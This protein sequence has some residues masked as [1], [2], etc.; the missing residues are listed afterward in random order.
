MP[1]TVIDTIQPKNGGAF[2]IV[3]D[4]DVAGG[5]QVQPTTVARDAIP[6]NNRKNGMLVYVVANT[7]YYQLAGDLVTWNTANLGANTSLAG[8]ITGTNGSNTISKIQ[9]HPVTITSPSTGNY[10]YFNG[11]QFIN[12][13]LGSV[14]IE[15]FN[16]STADLST[17][18][19]AAITFLPS[20]GGV[21][22]A[23]GLKGNYSITHSVSINKPVRLLLDSV[24]ITSTV[25]NIFNVQSNFV[26]SGKD[27]F[28][29]IINNAS[30]GYSI[31]FISPYII[32]NTTNGQ[33][34][35]L[36]ERIYFNG[37]SGAVNTIGVVDQVTEG[38][39]IIQDCTFNGMNSYA[40]ITNSSFFYAK[41]FRCYFSFNYGA[42]MNFDNTEL[43]VKECVAISSE[44]T[45]GPT[46]FLYNSD[47]VTIQDC[48]FFGFPPSTNPDIKIACNDVYS[49]SAGYFNIHDNQFRSETEYWL[50]KSRHRIEI[51]GYAGLANGQEFGIINNNFFLGPG[52]L[53]AT[54]IGRSSNTV[55]ATLSIG[56]SFGHGL[57]IGD[58][59]QVIDVANDPSF[60]GTFTVTAIGAPGTTQT[61]SWAQ[62]A[63]NVSQSNKGGFIQSQ[64][65]AAI[66][67]NT[68]VGRIS[69]NNN[70]FSQ[71]AIAV[72]D[73]GIDFVGEDNR[74][75]TGRC[76]F[77]DNVMR[78][79]A[80]YQTKEFVRGG[81][82]FSIAT[83]GEDSP[84]VS[85]DSIPKPVEQ[86]KLQNR[87]TFSENQN[88][89][90]VVGE[91]SV[92]TGA[93]DPLGTTRACHIFRTGQQQ[94]IDNGGNLMEA[95][96]DVSWDISNL[97]NVS[98]LIFWAKAG[99]GY[100]GAS[101]TS[102]LSVSMAG[103]INGSDQIICFRTISLSS[104]WKQ[105]QI[106]IVYPTHVNTLLLAV[107]PGG[108]DPEPSDCYVWAFQL[109]DAASQ[110]YVPT[111][112]SAY[113]SSLYSQFYGRPVLHQNGTVSGDGYNAITMS[114]TTL[115]MTE[116]QALAKVINIGGTLTLDREVVL[117]L[118]AGRFWFINN[119]TGGGHN[120][121]CGGS[122][123]NTIT[124]SNS[125]GATL[126]TDGVNFYKG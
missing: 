15:W 48:R 104:S 34:N 36:I 125:N 31:K 85:F 61:V 56:F 45:A 84:L 73:T 62:T 95:I 103:D 4:I 38:N 69:I 16:P 126:Y 42:I 37:G 110:A 21:I 71:F 39:L 58:T 122:S 120:L 80:G 22:D 41:V 102:T 98:N 65:V 43:L 124:I 54:S 33:I 30:D 47:F 82:M 23:T 19:N 114:D 101:T 100:L 40:I 29:T 75:R 116:T 28:S 13:S 64:N 99:D 32:P 67:L 50:N 94:M 70:T 86:V 1:V 112:A 60:N 90:Q 123:G 24:N 74:D 8:D 55:T 18:I 109:I 93:T 83:M 106:P 53:L 7:T 6:V 51:D 5:I 107:A 78:G 59:I 27:T 20:T 46:I 87:L 97:P 89:W 91:V 77:R 111:N 108:L 11:A 26:L 44:G 88:M 81:R 113:S 63:S 115:F 66:A 119:F 118:T 12:G 52:A 117:P 35:F 76:I 49:Y 14:K 17:A 96:A 9:N 2:P 57:A 92:T 25:S 79:S 68:G 105:Y 10:L 121:V 3:R 72:D